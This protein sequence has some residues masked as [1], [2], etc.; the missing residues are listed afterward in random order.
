MSVAP[1]PNMKQPKA[2]PVQEW[3]SP[4]TTNM[5]GLRWR[6][7]HQPVRV[8]NPDP[9]PFEHGFEPPRAARIVDHGEIDPA[10]HDLA[11][12]NRL[13]AGGAG[14]DLLGEGLTH[15]AT[16]YVAAGSPAPSP[17]LPVRHTGQTQELMPV[18]M[19]KSSQ[20]KLRSTLRHQHSGGPSQLNPRPQFGQA[21]PV[22][23]VVF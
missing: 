15:G 10:G 6:D 3:L 9:E 4:P 16:P 23:A 12:R 13:A 7:H 22:F 19:M 1:T 20:S 2:P 8:P 17:V 5:P 18:R 14:D 11:G 21:V